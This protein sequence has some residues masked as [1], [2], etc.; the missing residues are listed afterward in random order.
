MAWAEQRITAGD[1]S[2]SRQRWVINA[3]ARFGH[4]TTEATELLQV[5]ERAQV[6]HIAE[7]DRLRRELVRAI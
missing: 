3:L 6:R 5:F 4:D 1:R 7:C 2:I